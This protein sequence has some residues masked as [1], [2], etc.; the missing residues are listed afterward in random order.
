[1]WAWENAEVKSTGRKRRWDRP[2]QEEVP[3][4]K[5]LSVCELVDWFPCC[6]RCSLIH[7]HVPVFTLYP[8]T[9]TF[10]DSFQPPSIKLQSETQMCHFVRTFHPAWGTLWKFNEIIRHRAKVTAVQSLC[11]TAGSSGWK[12]ASWWHGGETGRGRGTFS[13]DPTQAWCL[14]SI[15]TA[16]F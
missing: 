3:L 13:S 10:P 7:L 15:K 12:M 2:E 5:Q 14:F 9:N 4:G 1:M 16:K 11:C 6:S 8:P